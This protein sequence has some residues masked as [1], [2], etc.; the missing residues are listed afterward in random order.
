[1]RFLYITTANAMNT[2]SAGV[3]ATTSH[4]QLLSVGVVG[5][6]EEVLSTISE[7]ML[8]SGVL[9]VFSGFEVT[10]FDELLEVVLFVEFVLLIMLEEVLF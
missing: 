2:T 3:P 9:L 1:M 6:S 5:V 7:L 8:L 4:I 10:L